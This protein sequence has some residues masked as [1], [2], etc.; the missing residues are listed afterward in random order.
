MPILA[1]APDTLITSS[2]RVMAKMPTPHSTNLKAAPMSPPTVLENFHAKNSAVSDVTKAATTAMVLGMSTTIS[3]GCIAVPPEREVGAI[4]AEELLA[5]EV[6][7]L[8]FGAHGA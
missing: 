5:R 1:Y 6:R 4:V 3:I 7:A 2:M 8:D